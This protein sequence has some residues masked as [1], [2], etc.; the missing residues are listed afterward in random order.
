MQIYVNINITIFNVAWKHNC[1]NPQNKCS[2]FA[3]NPSVV[4]KMSVLHNHIS[5]NQKIMKEAL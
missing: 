1:I 3:E 2:S 4:M 5:W